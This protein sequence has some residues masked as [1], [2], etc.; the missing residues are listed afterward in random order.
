VKEKEIMKSYR[1]LTID[2]ETGAILHED[3]YEYCGIVAK[4][5]GGPS[6]AQV[7]EA[8]MEEGFD[9]TLMNEQATE[10]GQQQQ[11]MSNLNKSLTP[12][13]E[14]GPN[15]EGFSAGE[16]A[17]MN[18]KALDDNGAN[19]ANAARAVN[20]QLAGKSSTSGLATGPQE[21]IKASLASAAAGNTANEELGIT[22]AD[23][24]QGNA[25][26]ARAEGGLEALNGQYNPTGYASGA[27]TA[28]ENAFS[29]ANTDQEESEQGL[30]SLVG[31]ITG[32]VSEGAGIASGG[33]SN[34]LSGALKAV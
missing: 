11:I 15:Q 32:L 29:E 2:I 20:G 12:I 25:N 34:G 19:Y 21:Q 30:S 9:Q 33:L 5:C 13:V 24:A 27:N 31:G 23:Y 28:N 26:W 4:F 8:G 17:A 18:T 10:F 16:L 7:Q 1:S 3:S 14:A 22:N 6:S